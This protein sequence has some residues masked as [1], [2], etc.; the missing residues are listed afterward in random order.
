[1][2][3][4]VKSKHRRKTPRVPVGCTSMSKS[5]KEALKRQLIEKE[6]SAPKPPLSEEMKV[7]WIYTVLSILI[8][9]LCWFG[10]W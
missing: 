1:M 10:D 3:K 4:M 8:G 9:L 2:H 7:T 6:K 5:T